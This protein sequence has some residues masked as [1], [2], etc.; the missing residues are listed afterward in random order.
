MGFPH[1]ATLLWVFLYWAIFVPR[2]FSVVVEQEI[3]HHLAPFIHHSFEPSQNCVIYDGYT[4]PTSRR[5]AVDIG[6]ILQE[7]FYTECEPEYHH[8]CDNEGTWNGEVFHC[9]FLSL[10][11][12][13]CQF[14]F[15]DYSETCAPHKLE[16]IE[17]WFIPSGVKDDTDEPISWAFQTIGVWIV[18]VQ[19]QMDPTKGNIQL[20]TEQLYNQVYNFTDIGY[21]THVIISLQSTENN[22]SAYI[23]VWINSTLVIDNVYL[24]EE[25]DFASLQY[26][27]IKDNFQ[28]INTMASVLPGETLYDLNEEIMSISAYDFVPTQTQIDIL[29]SMG[30]NRPANF[31]VEA[32]ELFLVDTLYIPEDELDVP[33]SNNNK[34]MIMSYAFIGV[35]VLLI[36]GIVIFGLYM[37][38]T[39]NKAATY[40]K[41]G[42][43]VEELM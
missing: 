32:C 8:V 42:N 20:G 21:E 40:L 33:I 6:D 39:F 23:N 1:P 5:A 34:F 4:P 31:T 30:P 7:Y 19:N 22:C 29:Y 13:N 28:Y 9:C 11:Y 2:I 35:D 18:G 37:T 3:C 27:Y 26:Y 14:G 43:E 41:L 36:L 17:Y 24:H 25:N 16:A 10:E 12:G 15:S 38:G